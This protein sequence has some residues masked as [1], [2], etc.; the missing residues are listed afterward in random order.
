[1][2]ILR[3]TRH[4]NPE[5]G[6][7]ESATQFLPRFLKGEQ[8]HRVLTRIIHSVWCLYVKAIPVTGRAR[9][10]ELRRRGCHSFL[11]SQLIDGGKTVSFTLSFQSKTVDLVNY[12]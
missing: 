5:D 8:F 1:M 4:Y 3:T 9:P 6:I 11:D 7:R 2:T 10:I 12:D